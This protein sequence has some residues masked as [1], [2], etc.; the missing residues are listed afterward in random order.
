MFE[1]VRVLTT[2]APFS[3]LCLPVGRRAFEGDCPKQIVRP[4]VLPM[5]G[6]KGSLGGSVRLLEGAA[7]DYG[8]L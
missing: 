5:Q 6:P 7:P 3:F 1:V 8:R 2:P 4:P